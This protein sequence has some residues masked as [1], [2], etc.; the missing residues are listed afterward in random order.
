[1][2][3]SGMY[4]L[5][6]VRGG[7][8]DSI[9]QYWIGQR[10]HL[11]VFTATGAFRR[12]VGRAGNGP[13]EFQQP[14]HLHTDARGL[15]HVLDPGNARETIVSEDFSVVA[16]HR[17]PFRYA[18]SVAPTRGDA[19][20][21]NLWLST[22]SSVGLLLHTVRAGNIVQ[23]FGDPPVGEQVDRFRAERLVASDARGN[24][25]SARRFAFDI[26]AY[27]SSGRRIGSLVGPPL[28]EHPVTS[29]ALN[30]RDN[31]IPNE[32]VALRVDSH[33]RLWILSRQVRNGWRSLV[34]EVLRPDGTFGMNPKAGKA[35][36]LA[37]IYRSRLDVIDLATQKFVAT[38]VSDELFETFLGEGL[39]LQNAEVNEFPAVAVWRVALRSP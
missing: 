39:L 34:V 6:E 32:L 5:E 29:P 21:A 2:V 30:L 24:I 4:A 20:V 38:Q 36:S 14:T 10:D 7:T 27:D 12:T 28:N 19:Y 11:K 1:M 31:P 16:E 25:Y 33:D 17:L 15:V 26:T 9:G 8:Q 18:F 22:D 35:I 3:D 13:L 23:S 37:S